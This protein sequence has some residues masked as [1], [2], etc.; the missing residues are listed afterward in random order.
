MSRTNKHR[1]QEE[2]LS[3]SRSKTSNANDDK[4]QQKMNEL[5]EEIRKI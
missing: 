5:E 4:K 2:I 3:R 1:K